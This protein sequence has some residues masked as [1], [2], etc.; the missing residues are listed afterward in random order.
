MN[1]QKTPKICPP[2][3]GGWVNTWW[4]EVGNIWLWLCIWM[5]GTV[6]ENS[7]LNSLGEERAVA[8]GGSCPNCMQTCKKQFPPNCQH[9][10]LQ[11]FDYQ[12]KTVHGPGMLLSATWTVCPG[13]NNSL[14]LS[15]SLSE[16][17]RLWQC[18]Y[19]KPTKE[20]WLEMSTYGSIYRHMKAT[21]LTQKFVDWK[22]LWFTQ[23]NPHLASSFWWKASNK[24]ER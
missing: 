19:S 22:R 12:E 24:S 8:C 7:I 6:F 5:E 15:F 21:T 11:L 2:H 17:D 13:V 16:L 3:C 14:T 10:L 4:E 20:T 23:K 9:L 18:L 1:T